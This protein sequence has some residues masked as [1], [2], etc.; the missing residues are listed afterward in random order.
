MR[1]HQ[2][3]FEQ[4][5]IITAFAHII[6][7]GSFYLVPTDGL[8]HPGVSLPVIIA[9]LVLTLLKIIMYAVGRDKKAHKQIGFFLIVVTAL[10]WAVIYG[11]EV[12]ANVLL[13]NHTVYLLFLI[14]G[15]SSLGVLS[16]YKNRSLTV[17]YVTTI[18]FP[19][20]VFTLLYL[21]EIKGV[22]ALGLALSY[23]FNLYFTFIHNRSW[24]DFLKEKQNSDSLSEQLADEKQQ[25]QMMNKRLDHA[26][27]ESQRYNRL[28][29][30]F[31][32]TVSHE[33]R[34]PM[35]GVIG[36]SALLSETELTPEQREYNNIIN[37][38]ARALLTIINDILDFSKIKAGKLMIEEI[39][40]NIK[41]LLNDIVA[42][43]FENAQKRGNELVLSIDKSVPEYIMGDPTRIRQI[44]N[45][46]IG[47]AVKFTENGIIHISL[48]VTDE[49]KLELVVKDTGIGIPEDKLAHI[50][51]KFT[52]ADS[53]TTRRFGGTGLGLA[54]TRELVEC[55]KGSIQVR[56]K[57]GEGTLFTI[58]LPLLRSEE[59]PEVQT[60]EQNAKETDVN[61]S[62]DWSNKKVL[63]VEDNVIN[64]K[65]AYNMLNINGL[66]IDIADSGKAALEKIERE[67]YDC[68]LMD[69]EMP[70]MDGI[71]TT[72]Q[73][74]KKPKFRNIPILAVTAHAQEGVSESYFSAGMND[75]VSKPLTK[76]NIREKV[77][78]WLNHTLDE[79]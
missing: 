18:E 3:A 76:Q 5:N 57:I 64:Q 13:T 39:S 72:R 7:Y 8:R 45:N 27:K 1:R 33:I 10:F 53:S 36:M 15:I 47:N 40:F 26:L 62:Y 46:L 37:S 28:K 59:S 54:I 78:Y 35:N 17:A 41:K 30:Q 22:I 6:L 29:D 70:E 75:Y 69:I 71:E 65:V 12:Y 51:D 43:Q 44:L 31:V 24:R 14:T 77:A 25:L 32:A 4:N 79:R 11:L 9:L 55:M 2:K 73:I 68:I 16:L 60:P 48:R 67:N 49:D 42:I 20:F 38:S 74:R 61:A 50:F 21:E 58:V 56:S 23:M 66:R 52:Q 34:T 19:P 63:L